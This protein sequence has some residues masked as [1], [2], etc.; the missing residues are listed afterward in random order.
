VWAAHDDA[1]CLATDPRDLPVRR[2]RSGRGSLEAAQA[3]E[4]QLVRPQQRRGGHHQQRRRRQGRRVGHVVVGGVGPRR[5]C[6]GG[7]AGVPR[8]GGPRHERRAAERAG[9]LV[10]RHPAVEAAAVEGVAAVAEPPHLVAGADAAQA[11]R[12]V[13]APARR[14]RQLLEPHHGERLLDEHRRYGPELRPPVLQRRA[15]VAPGSLCQRRGGR[16]GVIV[17]AEVDEVAEPHGVEGPEEEAVEVPQEEEHLQQRAREQH[18]RVP[19]GEAH[20]R[21]DLGAA[22]GQRSG[23]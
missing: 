11:H 19:H 13:A 18:L 17:A 1:V 6:G 2:P 5:G 7:P 9:A 3:A 20:R 14:A 4:Q 22:G 16:R 8:G 12:A 23:A 15:R 21:V 10:V